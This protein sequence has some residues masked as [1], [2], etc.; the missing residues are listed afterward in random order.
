MIQSPSYLLPNW[1]LELKQNPKIYLLYSQRKTTAIVECDLWRQLLCL[2]G[3]MI[4]FPHHHRRK[5]IAQE[6]RLMVYQ[7]ATAFS[8]RV[9]S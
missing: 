9:C 4:D 1:P 7:N 8:D 6:L 2:L 5:P 3:I